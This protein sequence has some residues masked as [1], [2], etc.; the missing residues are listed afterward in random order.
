M[1]QQRYTV[2]A[3]ILLLGISFTMSFVMSLCAACSS[4]YAIGLK[5]QSVVTDDTIKLGDIFYDLPRDEERILGRAPQP[6]EKIVLNA[7]TLFRIASA[8]DL[9]WRPSDV[10]THVVLRREATIID[11]DEIKNAIHLA[12]NDKGLYGEYELSIPAKYQKI[13]LP[14]DE[15]A[16][17]D[18]TN[19]KVDTQHKNFNATL[20]APSAD[21]PIRQMQVKGKI[22]PVVKVPVL[23]ENIEYGRVIKPSDI[24]TITIRENR[25]SKNTIADPEKLIGMTARRIIIAGRPISSSDV[26]A[27]NLVERGQYITLS[28]KSDFMNLTTQVKALENGAKGDVI[29]VLNPSSNQTL[30]AVVLSNN[31]A[32]VATY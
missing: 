7:R 15:P 12:L 29:R 9:P 11:Y 26:V 30:Q 25:F 27:P 14:A 28:L 13:V 19:I 23:R 20:A 31:E 8:L 16:N 32:Q 17:V 10:M 24:D 6:G 1:K 22:F 21:N 2:R 4:A 5:E 3:F 18:I